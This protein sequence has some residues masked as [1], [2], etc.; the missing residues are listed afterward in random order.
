MKYRPE[1]DGLRAV[2]VLPVVL[3]HAG[4]E[5]F[6]GGFVGVDVFFVIS[7]YLITTIILSEMMQGEFSLSRFY[8]RRARRILPILFF[9]MFVALIFAWVLLNPADMKNFAKSLIAVPLFSSNILFWVDSGYWNTASEFKPLLHTWSLAVE[10]QYYVFFPLLLVLLWKR[11]V[12]SIVI[13]V[14]CFG[15][16]SLALAHWG[17]YHKPSATFYLLPTR[18]WEL[19]IGALAAFYLHY[20]QVSVNQLWR[21]L[22]GLVGFLMIA[23]AVV[24]FSEHTPFP[25]L[26]ALIP[27]I[28]TALIIV[29]S[30]KNTLVG[31]VLSF[32]AFVGV[33]LISY[34]VYLWHQPLLAYT[35]HFYLLAPSSMLLCLVALASIPLAYV[36]WRFIEQ[37]FR[38]KERVSRWQI[39][40]FSIVGSLFFIMVGFVGYMSDGFS[41]RINDENLAIENFERK[42]QVNFGLHRECSS[43]KFTLSKKCRTSETPL[44]L[45]WGDSYAMHLVDGIVASNS[46]AEIIQMT[47]SVCGPFI[48][49]APIKEPGYSKSWAEDCLSFNQQVRQWLQ[50]NDSVKYV[51]LSSPFEIYFNNP[52]LFGDGQQVLST[53]SIIHQELEKTIAEIKK[54]GATPIVFSPPPKNGEDLGRCLSTASWRGDD[55]DNCN[56]KE[57]GLTLENSMAY[58]LMQSISKNTKVISLKNIMCENTECKAHAGDIYL[59]RDNGHL[60][61]EGSAF[62]GE[63]HHFYQQIIDSY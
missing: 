29:F 45:V 43:G 34:G 49:I 8:E 20:K 11:G 42:L 57:G 9:V 28:G 13:A 37:P 50:K 32:K 33:G 18:V 59:Y 24:C 6:S 30:S 46:N 54:L 58:E 31:K 48:N 1:I 36:S 38:D 39:F 5:L 17:A 62:L 44:I 41:V 7:G 52:L 53:L 26:Y 51:V 22:F 12:E 2:A 4:I 27:T 60:S 35:K 40:V 10:E 23:Y 56:F 55:L 14:I 25:S 21:E 19:A 63:R 61:V 47:K 15:V 3:F 16:L